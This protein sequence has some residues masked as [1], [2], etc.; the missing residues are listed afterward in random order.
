M[1]ERYAINE[2]YYRTAQARK[3]QLAKECRFFQKVAKNCI[4]QAR[5]C[6]AAKKRKVKRT[7]RAG[8]KLEKGISQ[9]IDDIKY[10]IDFGT[11]DDVVQKMLS[12]LERDAKATVAPVKPSGFAGRKRFSPKLP[13]FWEFDRILHITQI[14][15]R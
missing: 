13:G 4:V 5:S 12:T 9:I 11:C 2:H 10:K 15:S 14:E 7:E 6:I 1:G 8:F 3:Q